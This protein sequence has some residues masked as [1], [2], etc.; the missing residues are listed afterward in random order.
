MGAACAPVR[1]VRPD[2]RVLLGPAR[3]AVDA[4]RSARRGRSLR[5]LRSSVRAGSPCR[6]SSVVLPPDRPPEICRQRTHGGGRCRASQRPRSRNRICGQ[7]RPFCPCP[8]GAGGRCPGRPG[9]FSW[10]CPLP[11]GDSR[12]TGRKRSSGS[13]PSNE[14]G[15]AR[16]RGRRP[17]SASSSATSRLLA[18]DHH[19]AWRETIVLACCIIAGCCASLRSTPPK[20]MVATGD[21]LR[22]EY[23]RSSIVHGWRR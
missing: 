7:S 2:W 5:E 17:P 6:G 3:A 14:S 18:A 19:D 20:L 23:Y 9:S 15:L 12:S 4:I 13:R 16:C 21:R 1:T 8:Y 22:E 11:A 10:T